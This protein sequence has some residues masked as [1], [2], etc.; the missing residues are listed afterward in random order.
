MLSIRSPPD[1]HK[2]DRV[3]GLSSVIA[4]TAVALVLAA[5]SLAARTRH[6]GRCVIGSHEKLVMR[7]PSTVITDRAKSVGGMRIDA[8]RGCLRA[9]GR[10][11]VIAVGQSDDY[12]GGQFKVIIRNIALSG[13]LITFVFERGDKYMLGDFNGI[14]QYNL[15]TGRHTL[16]PYRDPTLR[17]ADGGQTNITRLAAN[18][19]GTVAWTTTSVVPFGL[20]PQVIQSVLVHDTQ[21]TRQLD[22]AAYNDIGHLVMHRNTISWT[23]G[24]QQRTAAA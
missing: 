10:R 13:D 4:I 20:P 14:E 7:S 19:A 5:P 8:W 23:H 3:L 17:Y 12:P 22:S 2:R 1:L 9:L 18:P 11:V 15:R 6:I 16:D 21:G 24:G